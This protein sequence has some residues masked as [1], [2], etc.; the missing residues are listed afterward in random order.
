[1]RHEKLY[2]TLIPSISSTKPTEICF[3]SADKFFLFIE[4]A[5]VSVIVCWEDSMDL[6]DQVLHGGPSY[7]LMKKLA[8]YT[9]NI[10]QSDF[11][12]LLDMGVVS[13]KKEELFVVEYQQQYDPYLG[14]L[15]DNNWT[16]ESLII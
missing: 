9:V 3:A 1:M 11:K 13:E 2:I 7:I 6:V 8:Q 4:D 5:G 12:K 10:Y 16:T 14:L 15:T